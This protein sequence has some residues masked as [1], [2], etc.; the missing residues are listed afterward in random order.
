MAGYTS[1]SLAVESSEQRNEKVGMR[2]RRL[3]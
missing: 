3:S 2:R 1:I